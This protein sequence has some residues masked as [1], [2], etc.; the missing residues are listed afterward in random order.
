MM[1]QI[2]LLGLTF[3]LLLA[4]CM[5]IQPIAPAAPSS[6]VESLDN[7]QW[8]LQSFGAP[9][10]QILAIEAAPVTL[11]FGADG[12]A[13]GN[14]GCNSYRSQY[15]QQEDVIAFSPVISTRK[16]CVDKAAMQQEQQFFAA[17]QTASQFELTGE[18]LTIVYDSGQSVLTF[19]NTGAN[20]AQ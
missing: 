19:V 18:Q 17:L 6:G 13:T 2:K 9:A 12:Q 10:E 11:E 7:T 14:G 4:A 16:A 15:R 20:R 8:Q 1:N 3:M 5:P